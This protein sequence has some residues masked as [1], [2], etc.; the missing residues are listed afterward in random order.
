MEL[1]KKKH[2]PIPNLNPLL[3]ESIETMVGGYNAINLFNHYLNHNILA[4]Q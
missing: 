2:N 3:L 4:N 1:I